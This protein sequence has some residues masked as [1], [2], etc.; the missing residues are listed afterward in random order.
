[1]PLWK[2]ADKIYLL[3]R[4][5]SSEP[6]NTEHAISGNS[7]CKRFLSH[8]HLNF[9][10]FLFLC[11]KHVRYF[12]LGGVTL[13]HVKITLNKPKPPHNKPLNTNY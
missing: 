6:E 10:S 11:L 8:Y 12:Q 7:F 9:I 2:L 13:N 5:C 4:L 1:M 3:F